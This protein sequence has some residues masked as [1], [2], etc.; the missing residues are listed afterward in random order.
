[1]IPNAELA[2]AAGL[3]VENG[4]WVDEYCRTDDP[5]IWAAG[6]VTNHVHPL[7]GRRLRLETWQNAQ[8]QAIA[9]A[10]NMVGDPQP[11]ADVPWGWSDQLG[12]NLQVLGVPTSFEQ[13]VTRGDPASGSFTLFYLE[14]D[15]IAGV[16]AVNAPKRHSGRAPADGGERYRRSPATPRHR[17][18]LAVTAGVGWRY[19]RR[20][21]IR[22]PISR[23][24]AAA[25]GSTHL[26]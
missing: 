15:K 10:R 12:A 6:D 17:G 11:Y 9:A 19:A 20:R 25:P 7:L 1:M 8:N 3:K 5:H 26:R 16:N 23:S 21:I 4:L 13:A 24:A 2:A 14:G 22:R 18:A